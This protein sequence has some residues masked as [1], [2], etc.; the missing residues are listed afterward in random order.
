MGNIFVCVALSIF[1]LFW[2]MTGITIGRK[3][4]KNFRNEDHQDRGKVIQR[5][6]KTYAMVQCILWPVLAIIAWTFYVNKMLFN[7]IDHALIRHSVS[8]FRFLFTLF[9]CYIG[10]NSLIIALCRYSFI[11]YENQ[12]FK[13]GL[14]R[15]K[16]IYIS[17][18]VGIPILIAVLNELV[19]PTEMAWM[20]LFVPQNNQTYHSENDMGQFCTKNTVESVTQSLIYELFN[21]HL[22]LSVIHGMQICNGILICVALSNILE[23]VMYLHIFIHARR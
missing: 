7:K 6:M 22:S 16:C 15:I 2:A 20:C 21:Q 9:R 12:V 8:L 14:K 4:Y 23:G 19:T 3:L 10:F 13:I 11:V 1:V 18:S 17:S 5:I